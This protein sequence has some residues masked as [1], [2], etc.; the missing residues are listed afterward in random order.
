MHS[1]KKLKIKTTALVLLVLVSTLYNYYSNFPQNP[2]MD[3]F[4]EEKPHMSGWDPH[5][6]KSTGENPSDMGVG[7]V[8]NDGYNDI[9]T[10]NPYSSDIVIFLWNA[11]SNDWDS[12]IVEGYGY[13]LQTIHMGDANNDGYN[14]MVFT[15]RMFNYVSIL[16]GE[17]NEVPYYYTEISVGADVYNAFIGDV[18]DDGYNDVVAVVDGGLSIILWNDGLSDWDSPVFLNLADLAIMPSWYSQYGIFIADVNDDGVNEI[19]VNG[20]FPDA[21]ISEI[22]V[23][24]WDESDWEYLGGYMGNP[25]CVHAGDAD[26]DGYN[27][28]LTVNY[29][30]TATVHL[31]PGG[32]VTKPVGLGP[33]D[34]IMYAMH[35]VSTGDVNNDGYNDIATANYLEHTVSILLWNST[36]GDWDPQMKKSV[37]TNPVS[38]MVADVNNDGY[39][40][41][42]T[43]NEGN[44]SI[45]IIL[46]NEPPSITIHQPYEDEL[47]GPQA[48]N[49]NITVSDPEIDSMW[50]TLDGGINNQ[51]FTSN[52]TINQDLWDNEGN[53]T[54]TIDFYANDTGSNIGHA[55]RIIRKDII[56]P[57]ISVLKPTPFQQFIQVP[58]FNLSVDQTDIDSKW[59]TI[60]GGIYNYTIS[61]FEG[62]IDETAWFAAPYELIDLEFYVND[63]LNNI[64]YKQLYIEKVQ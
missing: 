7:D 44:A 34:Y 33:D 61:E 22:S 57:V 41:I 16:T 19:L 63:S 27:E 25:L 17:P 43:A 56:N 21:G 9:V 59:Y 50:Y 51:I 20:E 45:S 5:I 4:G 23:I 55:Q 46:W 29:G 54:V 28:I 3:E 18:N 36:S 26:N 12:P 47:F 64:G 58:F 60:D 53:G 30:N 48:P 35:L 37:G 42:V 8:N 40:D 1:N 62:F 14:D 32:S 6:L 11:T 10:V 39:A 15:D 2:N 31:A 13:E 52:G 38:I 24:G 49:F